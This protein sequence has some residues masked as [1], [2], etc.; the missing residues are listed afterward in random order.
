[1]RVFDVFSGIGG[2]S[3]GLDRAG[4]ETVGFC[5]IEPFCNAILEKR[6]PNV[7][8]WSDVKTLTGQ[9]IF[10]NCGSID[11]LAGGPP[12]QPSSNAGKRLGAADDRWLWPD[13]LRLV[14][15]IQPVWVLAE[16][17]RGVASL[18]IEGVQFNEWLAREFAA[19]GYE[20]LPIKLAAEDFG[21]PHRRERIFYIG[22]LANAGS[23]GLPLAA[24]HRKVYEPEHG[25]K[26]ESC[27]V[28]AWPERPSQVGAIS[29]ET[30]GL[31]GDVAGWL[32]PRLT[33]VGNAILP[34]CAEAIGRAILNKSFQ[35]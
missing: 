17:P 35:L 11:V 31:S 24:M 18:E 33:A 7:W 20:L 9:L 27:S 32:K 3:L 14:S 12:C 28:V 16:N 21:A 6:W 34:Q 23:V 15:E 5:E 25:Q 19:R 10:D 29:P 30:D 26:I 2:M 8:R 13:F 1:M 22:R 4:F